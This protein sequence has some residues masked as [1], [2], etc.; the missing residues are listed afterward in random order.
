M[1]Y[2]SGENVGWGLAIFF[3]IATIFFFMG[4][5]E[6]SWV[7]FIWIPLI[8]IFAYDYLKRKYND[9]L[10]SVAK[11]KEKNKPCIHFVEGA[12]NNP[13]LCPECMKI[14]SKTEEVLNELK[15]LDLN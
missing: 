9:A 12:L 11:K 13:H 8:L 15:E 1:I 7:L 4:Y 2:N 5:E 6:H 3:L 14:K 10:K